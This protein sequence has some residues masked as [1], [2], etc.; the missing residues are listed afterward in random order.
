META[1]DPAEVSLPAL[2]A[3][4]RGLIRPMAEGKPAFAIRR[5][6]QVTR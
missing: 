1:L 5:V 2:L 6:S 3:A 4:L